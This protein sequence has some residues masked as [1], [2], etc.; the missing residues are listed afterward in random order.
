MNKTTYRLQTGSIIQES[1]GAEG[2]EA[3]A[4]KYHIR[5][6]QPGQGST[7]LYTDNWIAESA[8]LFVAGTPMYLDHPGYDERPERSLRN[9]AGKFIEDATISDD[10][11]LETDVMVYPSY[12]DIVKEKWSDI[13]VS[14]NGWSY[15][16]LGP[17]GS[18]PPLDGLVSV[19]FVTAAGAGGAILEVLESEREVPADKHKED[20]RM[21]EFDEAAG[22]IIAALENMSTKF[23]TAIEAFKAPEPK[24]DDKTEVKFGDALEAAT[25]IASADLPDASRAHVIAAVESGVDYKKALAD[26]QEL[27][28]QITESIKVGPVDEKTKIEEAHR[29]TGFKSA[30]KAGK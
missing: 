29:I 14:I 7:G 1:D 2:L 5:I 28:K 18:V 22:K 20:T 25:A 21:G 23:D 15:A 3:G 16:D 12:N 9:L 8:P 24:T 19:D 30:R 6:I 11:A 4:G 26:E 13:G 17:D 10:G 27:I